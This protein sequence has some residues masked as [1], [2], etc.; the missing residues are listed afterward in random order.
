MVIG[1]SELLSVEGDS[2]RER[3]EIRS[4]K[5]AMLS[6]WS[7]GHLLSLAKRVMLESP[8]ISHGAF[9]H[10]ATNLI[11]SHNLGRSVLAHRPYTEKNARMIVEPYICKHADMINSPTFQ[12]I[13]WLPAAPMESR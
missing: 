11:S 5:S 6:R 4:L 8:P 1:P 13:N 2:I 10:W 7:S 3:F 12:P 9:A